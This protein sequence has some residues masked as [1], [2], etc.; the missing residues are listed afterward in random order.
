MESRSAPTDSKC[1][2]YAP[3]MDALRGFN[4]VVVLMISVRWSAGEFFL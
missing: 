1:W 3:K 4:P 2:I